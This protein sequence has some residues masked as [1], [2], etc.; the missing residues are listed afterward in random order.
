[1]TALYEPRILKEGKTPE[2]WVE[3]FDARGVKVS[4]RTLRRTARETGQCYAL[5]GAV[6]LLPEHIDAIW[7]IAPNADGDE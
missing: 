2:E 5:G 4:P 6:M 3:A 7:E 1:M